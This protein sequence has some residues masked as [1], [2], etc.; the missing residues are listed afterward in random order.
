MKLYLLMTSKAKIY[1]GLQENDVPQKYSTILNKKISN[2]SNL[3]KLLRNLK[4]HLCSVKEL[5][6]KK[7][8]GKNCNKKTAGQSF[9]PCFQIINSMR[10]F[11]RMQLELF[12]PLLINFL[13]ISIGEAK[14]TKNKKV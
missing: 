4:K 10:P 9:L 14:N 12:Y 13:P 6:A 1:I 11:N 2:E 8:S 7:M 3:N 5:V